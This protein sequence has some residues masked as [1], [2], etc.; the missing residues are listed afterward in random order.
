MRVVCSTKCS[1]CGPSA[2]QTGLAGPT[3]PSSA[4]AVASADAASE[5]G[6]SL[7]GLHRAAASEAW[8]CSCCFDASLLSAVR[9]AVNPIQGWERASIRSSF[10]A[11][12]ELPEF[13]DR[14]SCRSRWSRCSR[15]IRPCLR[16]TRFQMPRLIRL[17]RS[18]FRGR[19]RPSMPTRPARTE[20][21]RNNR[22]RWRARARRRKPTAMRRLV[23]SRTS[24]SCFWRCARGRMVLPKTQKPGFSLGA[25]RSRSTT[26]SSV[27]NA[28]A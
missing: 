22:S 19:C 17:R 1:G 27:S 5:A 2:S 10:S 9:E 24:S 28:S 6:R 23:S 25:A 11:R 8:A 4:S 3:D 14:R 26:K 15:W 21:R 20:H 16:S 13:P 7:R 12:A 18:R